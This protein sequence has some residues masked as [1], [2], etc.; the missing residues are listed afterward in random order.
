MTVREYKNIYTLPRDSTT[1]IS[2]EIEVE[3]PQVNN[4]SLEQE[5]NVQPSI[6]SAV[7]GNDLNP[8]L[9]SLSHIEEVEESKTGLTQIEK[10]Q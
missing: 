9:S 3:S 10:N 6:S 4:E 1:T 8:E 2:S 7:S 5:E